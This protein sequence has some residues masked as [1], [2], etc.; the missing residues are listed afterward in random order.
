VLWI[1]HATVL[2]ELDGMRLLTDPVLLR[3]AGPLHNT[4]PVSPASLGHLDAV[5]IS[6]VHRDHLDLPSLRGL[7]PTR[8]LVPTGA[9]SH[10]DDRHEVVEL[11]SGGSTAI[12][13]LTVSAVPALHHAA[14]NPF[15]R[16]TQALGYVVSG[17][18]TA[19]FV[20]D[21]A[22]HPEM[23]ALAAHSLDVALLPVGGWGL[24]LGRG[25]MD[26]RSAA[27]ALRLLRPRSAV[28]VHWGT[29]RLPFGPRLRPDRYRLPGQEFAHAARDLA[30]EVDVHLLAPS[31]GVTIG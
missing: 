6:H 27:R 25:H 20:G 14:R 16:A 13:P 7:E 26:A 5:L 29:L 31:G 24:T 10:L 1:G 17:S 15:G 21:S 4:S 19:Y 28:P 2:L 18:R 8:V 23:A 12:G 3:R 9:G 22:L 30:P 11:S